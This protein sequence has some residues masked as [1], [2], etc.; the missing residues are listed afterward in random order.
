[1]TLNISSKFVPSEGDP[2]RNIW[3]I[4]EAPGADEETGTLNHSEPGPFIGES[5]SVILTPCLMRNGLTRPDSVFITNLSHFRPKDNKFPYLIGTKE[6]ADG[7][8]EIKELLVKNKPTVICTLGNWPMYFL[9]GKKGKVAGSGILNW[10][11]SILTTSD[12]MSPIDLSGPMFPGRILFKQPIKVIPTIHPAAVYRDRKLYPIFDQD[13]KRV[14]HDSAFRDLQLPVRKFT[15]APVG[16]ELEHYVQIL[17]KSDKLAVD[18]ETFGLNIGCVGFSNDPSMGVCIVNDNT[19]QFRDSIDRLL[20]SNI[21][22]ILHFSIFDKAILKIHGFDIN[23]I[24]WDNQ[25]AQCI[26]WPEMPR[27]H[28]FLVSILTREPYYKDEAKEGG[29]D[30]KKWGKRVDK[31]KLWIYNCKDDATEYEVQLAQEKELNEGPPNWRKFFN[32]SM[33]MLEV[34]EHISESGM[35]IDQDRRGLLELAV[36][37]KYAK[38]QDLLERLTRVGFNANSHPQ[39]QTMLYDTLK[40]PVHRHRDGKVTAD[41]DALIALIAL[42]KEKTGTIRREKELAEWQTKFLIVKMIM[43]IRG[44]RKLLSYLRAKISMDGRSRSTYKVPATETGRWAAEK[45]VDGTGVNAMTFPRD[46]VELPPESELKEF[47]AITLDI[48]D[49]S[50]SDKEEEDD[51]QEEVA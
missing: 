32:F 43:L 24:Y 33:E 29:G 49:E 3:F 16:D 22:K 41:E 40:L 7:I 51:E 44:H 18:I 1:M 26:M 28:K 27:S 38:N 35:L 11:G 45:Y 10:R 15:V 17:L 5:G 31:T 46:Y 25:V 20:L 23:N 36:T 8:N 13:I 39:V 2:S 34:A 50:D 48:A 42:C 9:T 6:L 30:K 14:V 12:E 37:Y 19:P 21:P 4:G 47:R